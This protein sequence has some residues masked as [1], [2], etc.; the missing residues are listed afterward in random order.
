MI[1]ASFYS[2]YPILSYYKGLFLNNERVNSI[3][4]A[5]NFKDLIEKINEIFS[6]YFVEGI[7]NDVDID[8]IEN[9]LRDNYFNVFNKLKH[10]FFGN[11]RNFSYIFNEFFNIRNYLR[12]I[13]QNNIKS[14]YVESLVQEF[15]DKELFY[16]ESLLYNRYFSKT[17]QIFMELDADNGCFNLLNDFIDFINLKIV[18]NTAYSLNLKEEE[19]KSLLNYSGNSIILDNIARIIDLEFDE[20]LR[21]I[22]LLNNFEKDKNWENYINLLIN[23]KKLTLK[24][25]GGNPFRY[26]FFYAF[27]LT[28][29]TD[30]E[31]LIII[32]NFYK[33]ELNK[34]NLKTILLEY[35]DV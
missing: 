2:C 15:P 30:Y 12:E 28:L 29:L 6:P 1:S 22:Q 10:F 27:F 7:K 13:S 24:K 11:I 21:K 9:Q 26:S 19:I 16:Y 34:D 32:L 18:I 23:F 5:N 25:I 35:S 17:K 3:L 8:E 14:K 4:L 33:L 31:I 20:K